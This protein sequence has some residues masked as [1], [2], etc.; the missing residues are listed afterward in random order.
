[1]MKHYICTGGCKGESDHPGVCKTEECPLYGHELKECDCAD[2]KHH[3][4][5]EHSMSQDAIIQSNIDS[6]NYQS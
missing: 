4:A 1:M 5:F 3:G 2:G 6:S